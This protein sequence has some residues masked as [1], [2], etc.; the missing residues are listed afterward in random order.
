M[1]IKKTYG[2]IF[3][4]I[5][6][7]LEFFI[8]FILFDNFFNNGTSEYNK[9]IDNSNVFAIMIQNEAGEY[10]ITSDWPSNDKYVLNNNKSGCLNDFGDEIDYSLQYDAN[11]QSVRVNVSESV[12]CYL[13]FD[14]LGL[15][16]K[17]YAIYSE[18]DNSLRFYK[19]SDEVV[20]GEEYRGRKVTTLYKDIETTEY[21][22]DYSNDDTNVTWYN[23][24]NNWNCK[25]V[26]VEDEI[27]PISTAGWFSFFESATSID[28]T[29][30]DTSKVKD[31]SY[32]F[33]NSF[34]GSDIHIIG[35]DNFNTS[36]VTN[37]ESMFAYVAAEMMYG[38]VGIGDISD[39]NVSNVTNMNNMFGNFAY[40]SEYT[41]DLS[42][43]KVNPNVTHE[44]FNSG[45]ESKVIAPT[46]PDN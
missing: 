8:A 43:W 16:G 35:L 31:M 12:K 28:V 38:M 19:N 34:Y 41:L 18:T 23:A 36:N 39:W 42:G 26:V 11:N 37:M 9:K 14:V 15:N 5:V 24:S 6:I 46:W 40:N 22:F 10:E 20:Q 4:L 3:L 33:I 13:Y 17:A 45:V 25:T 21:Y 44:N 7:I 30:L 2:I 27:S 29:K 1:K 32:M